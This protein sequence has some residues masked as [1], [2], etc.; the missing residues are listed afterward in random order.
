MKKTL[1]IRLTSGVEIDFVEDAKTGLYI[2]IVDTTR[3]GGMLLAIAD[4]AE[5]VEIAK[6]ATEWVGDPVGGTR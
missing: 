5:A 4:E 2:E 6:A 3:N 1:S